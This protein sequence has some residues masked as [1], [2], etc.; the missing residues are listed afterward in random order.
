L[1]DKALRTQGR[2]PPLHHVIS[3]TNRLFFNINI[4]VASFVNPTWTSR[5]QSKST[6]KDIKNVC[7]GHQLIYGRTEGAEGLDG[8]GT[9]SEGLGFGE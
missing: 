5:L 6:R 8:E 9:G 2:T 3:S 1:H 7:D 4:G